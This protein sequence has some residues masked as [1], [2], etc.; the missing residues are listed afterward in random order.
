MRILNDFR[1]Y[2][3]QRQDDKVNSAY[4]D[5]KEVHKSLKGLDLNFALEESFEPGM[6][7]VGM[8]VESKK[9]KTLQMKQIRKMH[10]QIIGGTGTG[11]SVEAANILS[12]CGLAGDAV[13]V[14]DPKDDEYMARVLARQAEKQGKPFYLIDLRQS[15]RPVVSLFEGA[16]AYQIEELLNVA[17]DSAPT[18]SEAD[19][20]RLD[21]REAAHALADLAEDAG[22]HALPDLLQL[23]EDNRLDSVKKF[24]AELRELARLKAVTAAESGIDFQKAIQDE[25]AY[26][27]VIGSTTQL[28]TKKATKTLLMRLIQIITTRQREGARP[29][30][31][32]LDE[33]KHLLSAPALTALGTIRDRGC[34][35]LLAHQS[36]GG[37]DDVAGIPPASV[38]GAVLDNTALKVVYRASDP[39]TAKYYSEFSGSVKKSIYSDR[40][41]DRLNE[42]LSITEAEAALVDVNTLLALPSGAAVVYGDGPAELVKI[43]PLE[44]A[45][46]QPKPIQGVK[47]EPESVKCA[48]WEEIGL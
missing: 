14:F 23:A 20:Y 43:E 4:S 44:P 33:L 48:T 34:H 30:A 11:K 41:D 10:I 21:D 26:I 2:R 17:F 32:C 3:K 1:S 46:Q 47:W 27:Y 8:G 9:P 38:R 37:L 13:I 15:A 31:L 29:V 24:Y 12:Q 36:L 16:E 42:G 40:V 28:A 45:E 35:L 39:Q 25:G 19:F 18:G 5:I 6:C 22:V 7:V